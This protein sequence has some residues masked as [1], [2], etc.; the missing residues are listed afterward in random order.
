[1]EEVAQDQGQH[2]TSKAFVS[3]QAQQSQSTSALPASQ[4]VRKTPAPETWLGQVLAN[5]SMGVR[6]NAQAP[7]GPGSLAC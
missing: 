6:I 7:G 4:G 1:M 2:P 5:T 3:I